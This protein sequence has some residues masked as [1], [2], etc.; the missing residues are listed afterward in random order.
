MSQ[1]DVTL[2][3]EVMKRL[4]FWEFPRGSRPYDIAVALILLFIFGVPRDV[5]K[6]QPRPASIV[7]MPSEQGAIIYWI[8][9]GLLADTPEAMR[10]KVATD[11]LAARTG[12][13]LNVARIEPFYDAEQEVRGFMVIVKQ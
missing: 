1:R 5:F 2:V 8:E 7:Q 11:L 4:I 6:D 3:L 13:R 9:T 12:K 10:P